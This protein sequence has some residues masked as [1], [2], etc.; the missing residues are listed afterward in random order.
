MTGG[1]ANAAVEG[2]AYPGA[3][4]YSSVAAGEKAGW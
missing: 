2:L 1:K 3:K 4:G